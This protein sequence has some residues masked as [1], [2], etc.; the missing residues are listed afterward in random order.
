MSKSADAFRTISEVADWLGVQTHV[1]RF[2]ESKF[3]QVKPVKRAGG[4]RYYRPADMLLLGGIRKLLHEDGLTIKGVQKILREEGMAYVADMSQPLDEE[5]SAQ[6]DGD[7]VSRMDIEDEV[8]PPATAPEPPIEVAEDPPAPALPVFLHAPSGDAPKVEAEDIPTLTSDFKPEP[9][10]EAPTA[11]APVAAAPVEAAPEREEEQAPL[12]FDPPA[13]PV[14]EA[15][16]TPPEPVEAAPEDPVAEVA[17]ASEPAEAAPEEPIAEV[18]ATQEAEPEAVAP[19]PQPATA[20]EP[21]ATP[22]TAPEPETVS[23]EAVEPEPEIA[24]EP[25]PATAAPTTPLPAFLTEPLGA[26]AETPP[27]PPR[28]RIVDVPDEP[29]PDSVTVEPSTLTKVSKIAHLTPAQRSAIRPLVTQL[30]ALRDHMA[31][32]RRPPR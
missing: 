32:G 15:I 10:A 20:P 27:A 31:S 1:L 19:E 22:D 16:E 8:A 18:A 6:L 11:P 5:T 4:R 14:P 17:A 28:P 30:E 12:P 3:T 21:Q 26:P 29:D 7:L 9:V 13:A 2:W 25:V 24:A 23:V